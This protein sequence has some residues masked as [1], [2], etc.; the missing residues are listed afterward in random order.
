[1]VQTKKPEIRAAIVKAATELFRE[2]GYAFAS[3][4]EIARRA[5][6][7]PA[8]LYVYFG[9]KLEILF[10]VYDPWLRDRIG[11]ME[12]EAA[13]IAD[14]AARLRFVLRT[15]WHD[16]P[17][18][19]NCFANNLMQALSGVSAGEGY[20][21]ELLVWAEGRIEALIAGCMPPERRPLLRDGAL[22]RLVFMAFDGFAVNH[23]LLGPSERIDAIVGTVAALLGGQEETVDSG[24]NTE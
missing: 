12:A 11:Q 18:D 24:L 4:S 23:N 21:R 8:N 15:L 9:S 20:S 6:V 1:M 16:I 3:M 5:K 22:V 7:S 10:A 13:R 17:G 2:R 19:E 14:P